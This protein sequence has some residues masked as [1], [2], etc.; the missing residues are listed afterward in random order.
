MPWAFIL[1][2]SRLTHCY[3]CGP[4]VKYF[5]NIFEITSN[6][7]KDVTSQ[8]IDELKTQLIIDSLQ[9]SCPKTAAAGS[10]P[11]GGLR[12]QAE[13]RVGQSRAANSTLRAVHCSACVRLN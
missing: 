12:E 2:F 6:E 1:T 11:A 3:I 8:L 7:L 5:N 9:L 10:C 4:V 13:G